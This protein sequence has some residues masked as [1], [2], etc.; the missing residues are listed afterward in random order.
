MMC[1]ARSTNDPIR[2]R[3]GEH[4]LAPG[5]TIEVLLMDTWYRSSIQYNVYLREYKIFIAGHPYS[6]PLLE[7]QPARWP[8]A[9][10]VS[11]GE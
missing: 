4:V 3:L 6:I 8:E 7:G 1:L 5:D 9:V 11:E 10:R 2:W